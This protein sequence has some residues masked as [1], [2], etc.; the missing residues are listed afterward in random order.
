MSAALEPSWAWP[1][2]SFSATGRPLASTRAWIFQGRGSS[3]SARPASAPCTGLERRPE[4]RP[5]WRTT[6]LFDVAAM[7][8]NA[9]RGRVDHLQIAVIGLRHRLEDAVPNADPRPA[10]EAVGAGRRRAVALGNVGPGRAGPEP[11]IDA[12]QHLPVV[13][14]RHAARLV[15]QQRLD[16]RPLKVG[17]LVTTRSAHQ[18][19]SQN[20]ESC[21]ARARYNFMSS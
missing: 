15:R 10:A 13:R 6:P 4:R 20:L 1:S 11:P 14:P 3:W 5:S 16:D 12:V 19:S 9:D 7:L 8:M 17:Q 21:E 2:V 18:G